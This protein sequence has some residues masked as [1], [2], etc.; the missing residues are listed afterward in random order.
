MRM[1]ALGRC[2]SIGAGGRVPGSHGRP[3]PRSAGVG[4]ARSGPLS[5]WPA[6]AG[7]LSWAGRQNAKAS[8]PTGPPAQAGVRWSLR[9]YRGAGPVGLRRAAA[10]HGGRGI[11]GAS[12]PGAPSRTRHST[13]LPGIRHTEPNRHNH[14]KEYHVTFT[15][16]AGTRAAEILD[17]PVTVNG[18]T[19]PNRI[20]MAPMT[21]QVSPD[22]LPG[23][24]VA[25]YYARRAAAGVGLIIT[26]GTSPGHPSAGDN[27]RVPRFHGKEQPAGWAKVPSMRRPDGPTAGG[28]GERGQSLLA[29]HADVPQLRHDR[30]A[31]RVH[32]VGGASTSAVSS[33]RRLSF[34]LTLI[35]PLLTRGAAF[36][37][38]APT[39]TPAPRIPRT[40]LFPASRTTCVTSVL[41]SSRASGL[42]PPPEYS[43]ARGVWGRGAAP[44]SVPGSSRPS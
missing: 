20:A 10:A 35:S 7:F 17:R 24:D 28:V 29:G 30:A 14:R 9:V 33:A 6:D 15:P 37:A 13:Q 16:T 1:S 8:E 27:D 38:A 5:Q 26:E 31:R 44:A 21:R 3:G 42:F 34:D 40:A 4:T 18:L 43:T 32:G 25:S 11:D 22:G 36:T 12:F 19:V 39:T 2:K 23:E 41:S